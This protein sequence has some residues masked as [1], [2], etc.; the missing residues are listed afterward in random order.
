MSVIGWLTYQKGDDKEAAPEITEHFS[1]H[2]QSPVERKQ[3]ELELKATG[4]LRDHRK[5]Y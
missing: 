1:Q 3:T 5:G 2:T 4:E